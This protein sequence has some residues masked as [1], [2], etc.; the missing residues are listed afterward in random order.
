M[1]SLTIAIATEAGALEISAM[2]VRAVRITNAADYQAWEIDAICE[3]FSVDKIKEKMVERDVFVAK[4]DGTIVGS[5]SLGGNK[6]HSMFVEPGLQRGGVGTK[7]VKH[8]E[9][10]AVTRGGR[11]FALVVVDHGAAI[12]PEAWI[13][14]PWTGRA[15]L[16]L[17]FRDEQSA[18]W[19]L[20]R[21]CFALLDLQQIPN[22]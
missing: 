13:P 14:L 9:D 21:D 4:I 3:N 12:L 6:L 15:A 22:P 19:W 11:H 1:T 17:H 20:I 2:I 18:W 10:H 5:V 8:L 16:R 7:L